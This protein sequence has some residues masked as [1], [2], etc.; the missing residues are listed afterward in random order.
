MFSKAIEWYDIRATYGL[1]LFTNKFLT[2]PLPLCKPISL[3]VLWPAS[4]MH[5]AVLVG[6]AFELVGCILWVII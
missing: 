4:E 2:V 1:L 5:K 6:K 3:G